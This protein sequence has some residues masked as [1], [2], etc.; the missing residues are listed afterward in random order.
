M[1]ERVKERERDNETYNR[2]CVCEN[3]DKRKGVR[4]RER[5]R[6]REM[7][8]RKSLSPRRSV[9]KYCVRRVFSFSNEENESA[10]SN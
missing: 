3:E 10:R 9:R 2:V 5:E 4:E 1:I 6:E 7:T 8:V